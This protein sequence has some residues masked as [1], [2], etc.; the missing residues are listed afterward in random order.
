MGFI[1]RFKLFQDD[2]D[3]D[4]LGDDITVY[5]DSDSDSPEDDFPE[6]YDFDS[7]ALEDDFS[8]NNNIDI[9]FDHDND[10]SI[11]LTKS[12]ANICDFVPS[13]LF[14]LKVRRRVRIKQDDKR[15]YPCEIGQNREDFIVISDHQKLTNFCKTPTVFESGKCGRIHQ[16]KAEPNHFTRLRSPFYLSGTSDDYIQSWTGQ[17]KKGDWY[18]DYIRPEQLTTSDKR[19]RRKDFYDLRDRRKQSKLDK[20]IYEYCN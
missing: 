17:G 14:P 8:K 16:C 19:P 2:S 6:N 11:F 3:S 10:L 1:N 7:A 20:V 18:N 13:L 12:I 4:L 5:Y 9:P 15:C